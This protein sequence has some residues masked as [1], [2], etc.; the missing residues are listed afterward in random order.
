MWRANLLLS[1]LSEEDW[2]AH[3]TQCGS[4][5]RISLTS[6]YPFLACMAD[7]CHLHPEN[8]VHP[9]VQHV[10]VNS[11]NPDIGATI[12]PDGSAAKLIILGEPLAHP[13]VEV[14]GPKWWPTAASDKV[15]CKL[16]RRIGR[17]GYALPIALSLCIGLLSDMYTTTAIP[18]SQSP[19]GKAKPRIRLQYR[20]SPISDFGI[21][22]GAAD[23]KGQ[24]K[25]AYLYLMDGTFQ[26]GQDPNDHYWI[27]FTTVRGETVSL[28]CAMFT[29]NFCLMVAGEPYIQHMLPPLSFAPAHFI[30][31][32]I[33]RN[34]PAVTKEAQRFTV[35]RNT[36]L[37]KA[38]EHS[39]SEFR[40]ADA[41]TIC[42]FMEKIAGRRCNALEKDL[43][44]K[45]SINSGMAIG[46]TLQDRAWVSWPKDPDIKAEVDPG[47]ENDGTEEETWKFIRKWARK[48]RRGEITSEIVGDAFR[49]WNEKRKLNK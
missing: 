45:F 11:P 37:H 28:D 21:A 4:T 19:D 29:F 10:I 25:L 5:D 40:S 47:E 17:E 8:P 38:V 2:P 9:A 20:S 7:S 12:L 35:L 16:F 31:R 39:A 18:A 6:F 46:I 3:K 15:R 49:A 48:H 14:S 23:V 34:A 32:A 13:Q 44:M 33:A 36:D 42:E 30:N 24:N 43:V 26:Q 1:G 41:K 22:K 27:Y